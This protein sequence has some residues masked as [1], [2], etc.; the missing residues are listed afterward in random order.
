MLERKDIEANLEIIDSTIQSFNGLEIE[1]TI[2]YL[3][4]I[5]SLQSLATETQASA[6]FRLLEAI[7]IELDRQAKLQNS[8]KVAPS[9]KKMRAESMCR[10]WMYLYEKATR[11]ATNV[12]HTIDSVRTKISYHKSELENA[13]FQSN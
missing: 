9:I 7:N 3:G 10:E 11:F 5:T 8:D 6:K 4:A 13:R 12:S 1:K 2:E